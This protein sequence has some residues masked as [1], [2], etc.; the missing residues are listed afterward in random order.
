MSGR[1]VRLVALLAAGLWTLPSVACAA[2]AGFQVP[3][4]MVR[5]LANGLTVAVFPDDRLPLVQVQLLVAAGSIHEAAGEGGVAN[6]TFQMLSQGTASRTPAA[7]EAG[8]AALGGS[9]GGNASREFSTVNGSFVSTDFEAGLELLA[10]AVT[11]A[12]LSEGPLAK[13]KERTAATIIEA[14]QDAVLLADA[15]LWATVY[16]DHP[17]GRPPQ[18]AVRTLPALSIAQVRRFY[19]ERYRPNRALLAI[20]GDVAPERAFKTAEEVFGDWGGQAPE[21]PPTALPPAGSGWRVRIVDV[22]DLARAELRIG[23]PAPGRRAEDYQAMVVARGLLSTGPPAAGLD[24]SVLSLRDGG[25]FSI[26]ARVSLDSVG[27]EVARIRSALERWTSE[28]PSESA[29]AAVRGR[30]VGGFPLQFETLDGVIAKWMAAAFNGL[31]TD[32]IGDEPARIGA[33]SAEG[34][35]GAAARWITPGRMVLV[36]LGPAARLRPQLEGLGPIEVVS[37]EQLADLVEAPSTARGAPLPEQLD[38]GRMLTNLAIAGH[39]GL[40]RLRVIK[41][42]SL[43]GDVEMAV[44]PD[45]LSGQMVQVRKEPMQFRFITD[46]PGFR[47]LQVLD[48]DHGWTTSLDEPGKVDDLDSMAVAGMRAGFGSD[49]HHMLLAA[50]DSTTRVAWRGQERVTTGRPMS[51]RSWRGM[52]SAAPCSWTRRPIGSSPRTRTK[53]GTPP[54]GSIGISG[55]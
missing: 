24:A 33:V 22:P 38:R 51:S 17:Y 4:P 55:W 30:L 28:P 8:L 20:A 32:A 2:A 36:A 35:R 47:T 27:A 15:Q 3:T 53:P 9:V 26:S 48:G 25:L 29:L 6:L 46:F 50:A 13:V 34:V 1:P 44:G 37:A 23:T 19:R 31:P 12:I 40:A 41:D 10:D 16:R 52:G 42:S 39:G 14:R 11:H 18:G 49:L 43:E 7:L 21:A 5:T 54:A 45:K